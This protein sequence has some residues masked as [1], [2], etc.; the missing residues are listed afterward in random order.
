M[1]TPYVL[2]FAFNPEKTHLLLIQ[3]NRP[4]WQAGLFNG[5]GG[6]IETYDGLPVNA[7]VREF[8]EET[9]LVTSPE[10]WQQFSTMESNFFHLTCFYTVLENFNHYQSITDEIVFSVSIEQLFATQ[11]KGCISNLSWLI[12]MLMDKDINHLSSHVRYYE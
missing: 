6:K 2:G 5:I 9:G 3:K 8:V 11:F 1:T 7:M 4:Q 10:Q 12:A